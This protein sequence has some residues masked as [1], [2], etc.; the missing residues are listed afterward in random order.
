MKPVPDNAGKTRLTIEQ[1]LAATA[2]INETR[3]GRH[4]NETGEGASRSIDRLA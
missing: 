2:R 3:N 1:L 4:G